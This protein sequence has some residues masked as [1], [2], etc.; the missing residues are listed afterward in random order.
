MKAKTLRIFGV[1][2]ASL[3]LFWFAITIWQH[4]RG[5]NVFGG[6]I[7]QKDDVDARRPLVLLNDGSLCDSRRLAN[8]M[9]NVAAVLYAARLADRQPTLPRDHRCMS[10]FYATFQLTGV[11]LLTDD[12]IRNRAAVAERYVFGERAA[13]MFD[14][15][16]ENLTRL[17]ASARSSIV[18]SGFYQSW[19]YLAPVDA[20]LRETFRF[21]DKVLA[22]ARRFLDEVGVVRPSA[23]PAAA[24][25]LK[26][27]RHRPI[28]IGIHV[29][30]GD[31]TSG[32][33]LEMGYNPPPAS[34]FLR[35][36]RYFVEHFA[37]VRFVVC[38]DDDAWSR[39]NL[40]VWR[41]FDFVN[42]STS[43]SP[44]TTTT[45]TQRRSDD[46][47]TVTFSSEHS[48]AVDLAI[49]SLCDHVITSCG[50]YGWWGAWL[51]NGTTIYYA[52]WPRRGSWL[53]QRYRGDDFYPPHWIGM[54]D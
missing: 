11:V 27:G 36:M 3:L 24:S 52:N 28:L 16:V 10:E 45:T 38:S 49:L 5:R 29:R 35:A 4:R 13:M 7:R 43:S 42:N 48:A 22:E 32:T 33:Y 25:S 34:Y 15:R 8:V 14:D 41:I 31:M 18:M 19:R 50:T 47:V 40:S 17:V 2:L 1:C 37:V 44:S 39:D 54:E 20:Q 46:D 6:Q 23:S 51:A 30:R 12:E 9:F 26:A 53:H 21:K